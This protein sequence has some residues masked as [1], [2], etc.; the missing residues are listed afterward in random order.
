LHRRG[1]LICSHRAGA[2]HEQG[3]ESEAGPFH[4]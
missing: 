1:R 2:G 3:K 4:S